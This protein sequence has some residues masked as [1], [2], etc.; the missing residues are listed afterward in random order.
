VL[1]IGQNLSE[2]ISSELSQFRVN[3]K[4]LTVVVKHIWLYG[5]LSQ[6][7]LVPECTI[8]H[9]TAKGFFPKKGSTERL[10]SLCKVLGYIFFKFLFTIE[11]VTII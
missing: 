4:L 2:C 1:N 11:I 8:Y 7:C 5:V 9:R 10:G 6:T 3:S